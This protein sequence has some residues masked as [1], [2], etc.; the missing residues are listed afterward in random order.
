MV[1]VLSTSCIL[2]IIQNLETVYVYTLCTVELDYCQNTTTVSTMGE[3]HSIYMRI[4]LKFY[5][6]NTKILFLILTKDQSYTIHTM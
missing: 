4:H 2:T 5:E 3:I 1:I 6:S